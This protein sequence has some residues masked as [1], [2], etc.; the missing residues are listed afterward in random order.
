MC[1]SN[2]Y[3]PTIVQLLESLDHHH[4]HRHRI[5]Y[6]LYYTEWVALVV[7]YANANMY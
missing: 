7:V 1:V 6:L 4:H 5:T 2:V 3:L